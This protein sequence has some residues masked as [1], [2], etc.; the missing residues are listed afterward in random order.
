MPLDCSH[1]LDLSIDSLIVEHFMIEDCQT[2]EITPATCKYATIEDVTNLVNDISQFSFLHVNCRSIRKNFPLLIELMKI[3]N[4]S[5]P[6][7]IAVT[8]TWLIEKEEF[9]L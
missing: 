4:A 8:E 7:A 2:A 1:K 9:C 3:L 5:P 6:S